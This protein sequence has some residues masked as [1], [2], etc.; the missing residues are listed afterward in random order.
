[1]G[2]KIVA[3]G[4]ICLDITPVIPERESGDIGD[5]LSPGRLI[6]VGKADIHTGGSVANTGLAMKLF[7]ADVYLAGKIGSDAFGGMIEIIAAGYGAQGGLIRK[8]GE[9]T[10]YSVVLAVPGKDRIF[11]HH[12]GANDTFS[13][14]D[15]SDGLLQGA[16]IFH[17][18]YPP[19]MRNVYE[20]GGA[21]LVR[22][23]KKARSAGAAA[24]VDMAAVDPNSRAGHAD[25]RAILANALPYTDIFV[26]SAEELM[27]ML[28]RER[29]QR[30]CGEAKG[31]DMTDVLSLERDVVPMAEECI[32]MGAKIVLIKCGAPGMYLHTADEKA[33][34][35][36]P[37]ALGLDAK[38]WAGRRIFEKSF[39]PD[40]ILSGTGA[41]DTCAAAL[42]T[43]MAEGYPPEKCVALAAA[44][45]ACCVTEYDALSGLLP[46]PEL[47]KKIA[48]GWKKTERSI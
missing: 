35:A 33:I 7:G 34:A 42:L 12:P 4:H 37:P 36:I 5:I 39:V 24:S 21:E 40:R 31:G 45:G 29:W 41:G 46:L 14:D 38:S 19:L 15:L 28:D 13:A 44:A 16:A 6:N 8:E 43:A 26:P 30:L 32:A 1:M 18:G 23:L 47:E 22:I 2:K 11:L 9:S 17:F 25:W 27:F 48:S 3:A 20:N 10:S